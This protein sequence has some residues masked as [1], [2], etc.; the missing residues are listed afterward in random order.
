MMSGVSLGAP[1]VFALTLSV[2][3]PSQPRIVLEGAQH[4]RAR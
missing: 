2:A 3:A 4:L 1:N